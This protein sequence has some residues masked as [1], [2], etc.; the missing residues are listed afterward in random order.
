MNCSLTSTSGEMK[1]EQRERER[2]SH[3]GVGIKEGVGY[4]PSPDKS[5]WPALLKFINQSRGGK[6]NKKREGRSSE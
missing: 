2:V 5:L 1:G 3:L 6:K 4:I